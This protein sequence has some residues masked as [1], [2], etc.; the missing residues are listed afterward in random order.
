MNLTTPITSPSTAYGNGENVV[1]KWA[2]IVEPYTYRTSFLNETE[3]RI[4]L[5]HSKLS[6]YDGFYNC[7]GNAGFG[8]LRSSLTNSVLGRNRRGFPDYYLPSIQ[9]LMFFAFQINDFSTDNYIKY[10]SIFKN[11][12]LKSM[13]SYLSS[14]SIGDTSLYSQYLQPVDRYTF[15]NIATSTLTSVNTV[16][17]FRRINLT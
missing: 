7:Y 10:I 6:K 16:K 13:P 1:A 15:G 17:F 2:L 3:P 4:L 9:E 8:G 11:D 12:L 5:P 14:T